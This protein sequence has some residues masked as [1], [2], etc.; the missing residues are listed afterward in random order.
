MTPPDVADYM[1][2][3]LSPDLGSSI[4]DPGAGAGSL[5]LAVLSRFN[6]LTP[7]QV[8]LVEVDPHYAKVLREDPRLAGAEIVTD[9]FVQWAVLEISSG[10]RWD[11]IIANPPYLNYH[12]FDRETIRVV[13]R[14][15]GYDFSQLTNTYALF[16]ALSSRLLA[17]GGRMVFITPTELLTTNYGVV[18]LTATC[19]RLD[20]EKLTVFEPGA[21]P[22]ED[23]ATSSCITSFVRRERR[24][25]SL[26]I[27][28]VTARKAVEDQWV[29]DRARA[30]PVAQFLHAP[31][32]TVWKDWGE[33]ELPKEKLCPLGELIHASRGI[34]TGANLFFTIDSKLR[35]R[36]DPGGQCTVPVISHAKDLPTKVVFE[37]ADFKNLS[38]SGSKCWLLYI[39][40]NQ[41]IPVDVKSYLESEQGHE[42][43]TRYLCRLRNP[44]YLSESQEVPVG[45]VRVFGRDGMKVVLNHAGARTL[46]CFHRLYHYSPPRISEDGLL[47][48]AVFLQSN[49]GEKTA[50]V[51]YRRYGSGLHKL[52]PADLERVLVPNLRKVNQRTLARAAGL[53]RE[54]LKH[55]RLT[56]EEADEIAHSIMTEVSPSENHSGLDQWVRHDSPTQ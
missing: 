26:D 32:E 21:E 48:L 18:A 27:I 55:G 40:S 34:A 35:E 16:M 52:E 12:D 45:F 1:A 2:S 54:K 31:K 39:G 6:V 5:S 30:V 4:L 10:R 53:V 17:H 8:T 51:Q 7:D 43:R 19:Q 47:L 24:N 15:T 36:I 50:K 11:R 29:T 13:N 20:F 41:D 49:L 28:H 38:D 46:T 56:K 37:K 23:A 22:F 42:V 14:A 3:I 25:D 9:G 33:N 44:W